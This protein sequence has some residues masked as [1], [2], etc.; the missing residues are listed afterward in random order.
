MSIDLHAEFDY[1]FYFRPMSHGGLLRMPCSGTPYHNTKCP[2]EMVCIQTAKWSC[3]GEVMSVEECTD[4]EIPCECGA[5][6][7][8]VMRRQRASP[9][10]ICSSCSKYSD[11]THSECYTCY[12]KRSCFFMRTLQ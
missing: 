11:G 2:N 7:P 3:C 1:K 12:H 5:T 9:P 8:L 10:E 6:N 4:T